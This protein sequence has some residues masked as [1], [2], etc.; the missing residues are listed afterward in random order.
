MSK[1]LALHRVVCVASRINATPCDAQQLEKKIGGRTGSGGSA[2][3][4]LIAA[5]ALQNEAGEEWHDEVEQGKAMG[6]AG[7]YVCDAC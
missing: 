1:H 5:M 2:Q 3:E 4:E 6:N 7:A